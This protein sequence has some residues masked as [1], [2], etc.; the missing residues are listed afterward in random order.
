[1][2]NNGK[3]IWKITL[4]VFTVLM[5]LTLFSAVASAKIISPTPLGAGTPPATAYLSA[6]IIILII[7][8]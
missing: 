4:S 2:K 1:M 8:R 5:M 3:S 6:G 7:R